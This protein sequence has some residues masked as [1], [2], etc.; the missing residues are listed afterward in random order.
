MGNH[1]KE[2]GEI[3]IYV[4]HKDDILSEASGVDLPKAFYEGGTNDDEED[5][6]PNDD[7]NDDDECGNEGED[8]LAHGRRN[9]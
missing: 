8:Q 9:L 4:D 6:S 7:A 5:T 1:L 3:S 2:F